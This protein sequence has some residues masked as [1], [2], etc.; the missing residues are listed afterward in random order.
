MR[1]QQ[2]AIRDT[3]IKGKALCVFKDNSVLIYTKGRFQII[4]FKNKE[5][6]KE[7]CLPV[8]NW[9]KLSCKLRLMERALHIEPRWA[10]PLE[11]SVLILWD[12]KIYNV[13][14][15]TGLYE[16][17]KVAVKGKPLNITLIKDIEGFSNSL[18]VGD[19]HRNDNRDEVKVF[20]K[21]ENNQEW[22]I[23]YIFPA[24]TIR[25]IHNIVPDE[26]NKRVLIFTGDENY[27]S[28]IWEA[29]DNFS[30]VRPLLI[31]KQ[32]YR[33]CQGMILNDK[34]YYATD[35]PSEM[36]AIYNFDNKKGECEKIVNLRGSCIYGCVYGDLW[37][38]STTCEPKAHAK[39]LIDYWMSNVPG[40][41]IIDDKIDICLVD[42]KGNYYKIGTFTSDKLPLRLFQ[43]ASASFACNVEVNN[44]ILFTPVCVKKYDMHVFEII[45]MLQGE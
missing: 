23:A 35:A 44:P 37:C 2:F 3:G 12:S 18:I 34:M 38:F 21:R 22:E 40:E 43:Y 10:M 36:N 25:H 42:L 17:E 24:G 26:Q 7:F 1:E 8:L 27:E 32:R 29:K 30:I 16:I 31:G 39:N 28:G 9:K 45:N 41:G 5:I 4:S 11:N 14:I 20:C 13:D 6:V 15:K 33:A 19:Y